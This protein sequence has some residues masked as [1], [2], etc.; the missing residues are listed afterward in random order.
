[1]NLPDDFIFSQSS[2]QD[3]V[4]C[5]RRFQLRYV[6]RQR[7]PAPEVDDML[8]FEMLAEQ[9]VRFHHLVHQHLAGIAPEILLKHIDDAELKRWFEAYLRNGLDDVPEQRT[10]EATLTVTLGDTLLLA[11]FDLVAAQPGGRALIVDWK[12]GRRMPREAWL[13]QRLQTVVYRYVLAAGGESLNNGL[14][15]PPEQIEMVYW[16]ADH[17]GQT[18][19]YPYDSAQYAADEATLLAVVREINT[20][21][22]FPLTDDVRHCRFCVYRSLCNRGV[23][24]G[25]LAQWDEADTEASDLDDFTIDLEQIAEIEF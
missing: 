19:R 1:M 14:A 6:L 24:A 20:R 13:A 7:W 18:L 16:Y 2:L 4:D 12:T 8:E 10:P 15:I 22:V 21:D 3:Y 17:D 11:K 23:S 5:P 9:G 25:P